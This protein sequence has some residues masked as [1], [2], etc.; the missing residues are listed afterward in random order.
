MPD[1]TAADWT[2]TVQVRTLSANARERVTYG[3]IAIAGVN[4]YIAGGV[5]L[6]VIGKFGMVRELLDLR[7]IGQE[8]AT[9]QYASNF[10]KVAHK[11]QFFEQ[12]AAGTTA[13]PEAD[14]GEVI[15]P[16][17]WRFVARGW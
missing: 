5:P 10:N 2:V 4:D 3:T 14:A 17:T 15:G 13:Q 1:L 6:P 16:R 8:G 12:D 11:M 9:S 7:L